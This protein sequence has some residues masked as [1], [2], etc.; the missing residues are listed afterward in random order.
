MFQVFKST[1]TKIGLRLFLIT[2]SAVEIIE[3]AGIITSLPFFKFSDFKA[4]SRAAV[5]LLTEIA[6]FRLWKSFFLFKEIFIG[7][8]SN[9]FWNNSILFLKE[10]EHNNVFKIIIGIM[11]LMI[12]VYG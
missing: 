4:I 8:S 12:I 1:S 7:H 5:P 6:Y 9:N 2:Q 3:K 10:I 11:Y